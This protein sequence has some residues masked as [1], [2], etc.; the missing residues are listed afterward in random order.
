MFARRI[1]SIV[2]PA[3]RRVVQ[4][5]VICQQ[6][7]MSTSELV[8]T[9]TLQN[10]KDA[11]AGES[12]TNR[13]YLFF[14]QRADV[15]GYSDVASVFRSIAEGETNHAHGHLEFLQEVGDPCTNQLIGNTVEN[16]NS[17]IIGANHEATEMY[18]GMAKTARAEG[19]NEVAEWFDTLAI[20]EK[21]HLNRLQRTLAEMKNA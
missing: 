7:A 6:R 10:L 5:A 4:P 12:M 16:L 9:K 8:N 3:A 11:F 2:A 18:P 13:R 19:L 17:A 1:A 21:L 15:E 20:A 14:A